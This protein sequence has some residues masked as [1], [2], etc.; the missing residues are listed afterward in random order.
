[1]KS[2]LALKRKQKK[3]RQKERRRQEE[4]GKSDP[5]DDNEEA[6][7]GE[8]SIGSDN[9]Q[10]LPASR[11][12]RL[13]EL[14]FDE[15]ELGFNTL[16]YET[17]LKVIDRL[18]Q[19]VPHFRSAAF[20]QLRSAMHPLVEDQM[21]K[22]GVKGSLKRK[23]KD[24][25]ELQSLKE[26]DKEWI[27]K[28]ALRAKRL[29]ALEE[30]NNAAPALTN[31]SAPLLLTHMGEVQEMAA[32][33]RLHRVAD[34]TVE[35][36]EEEEQSSM[37]EDARRLNIPIQCYICKR[38]FVDLHFFYDQLCP[39]CASLNYRKRN[40]LVEMDGKVALVTGA[41]VKIGFRK[42]VYC[43]I[44]RIPDEFLVLLCR[45]CTEAATVW[46]HRGSNEQ[47]CS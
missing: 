39:S 29:A 21:K 7:E 19:N 36:N 46:L 42:L 33:V 24:V 37:M 30:L 45:L 28:A 35:L 2:L 44:D 25:A 34:G 17:A 20:K 10:E 27:N 22:Y 38:P 9:I 18:A 12:S 43:G 47:V 40:E 13:N 3:Q 23:R 16:E 32:Q 31:G 41:R 6:S 8:E 11:A 5:V 26:Q 14:G 1:M 4:N 15:E